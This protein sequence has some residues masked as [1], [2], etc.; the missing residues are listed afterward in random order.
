METIKPR[1]IKKPA[2]AGRVISH[3]AAFWEA[4]VPEGDWRHVAGFGAA[5]SPGRQGS[6]RG[7]LREVWFDAEP[8][9]AAQAR[10]VVAEAWEVLSE[11]YVMGSL[12]GGAAWQQAP[13]RPELRVWRAAHGTALPDGWTAA[14][15]DDTPAG[16]A[17]LQ[18]PL[19][20][21]RLTGTW[22]YL[23]ESAHAALAARGATCVSDECVPAGS[24]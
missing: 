5:G 15:T 9:A 23:C 13:I 4:V 6:R 12:E 24:R 11:G 7:K 17:A 3:T 16:D 2:D 20:L 18:A 21:A 1:R 10:K 22:V 19:H 8:D 14:D